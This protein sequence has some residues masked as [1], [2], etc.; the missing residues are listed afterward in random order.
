VTLQVYQLEEGKHVSVEIPTLAGRIETSFDLE[1][2]G[3]MIRVRRRGSAKAWNVV[4]VGIDSIEKVEKAE[5]KTSNGSVLIKVNQHT[6]ELKIQ[7]R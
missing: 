4:L 3:D 1:R 7:L 6:G 5:V 2:E